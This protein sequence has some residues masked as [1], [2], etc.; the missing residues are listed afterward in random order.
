MSSPAMA[1]PHA[2]STEPH[3][4]A[5][6]SIARRVGHGNISQSP[7]LDHTEID[8]LPPEPSAFQDLQHMF[9]TPA[10]VKLGKLVFTGTLKVALAIMI[11]VVWFI[12]LAAIVTLVLL[13]GRL[14]LRRV[15]AEASDWGCDN[16]PWLM[17]RGLAHVCPPTADTFDSVAAS[18]TW[19][20]TVLE[21]LSPVDPAV[22]MR[23]GNA[24]S[25][26]VTADIQR[27]LSRAVAADPVS[28]EVALVAELTNHL[29]IRLLS[30][31]S[32][33]LKGQ[34][35]KVEE[36]DKT[37]RLMGTAVREAA[38]G[39]NP[40]LIS[41]HI[42]ATLALQELRALPASQSVRPCGKIYAIGLSSL[43]DSLQD[44]RQH[45]EGHLAT[46]RA[47]LVTL[48]SQDEPMRRVQLSLAEYEE[49]LRTALFDLL[50]NAWTSIRFRTGLG[51]ARIHGILHGIERVTDLQRVFSDARSS[52]GMIELQLD[53]VVGRLHEFSEQIAR[54]DGPCGV[55]LRTLEALMV[56]PS[57]EDVEDVG[58]PLISD[59]P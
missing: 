55:Y 46:L 32:V 20:A 38:L 21:G 16:F 33:D 34:A 35:A 59:S 57:L 5:P 36:I 53:A 28:R 54:E 8:N 22:A 40:L 17:T 18:D 13:G 45:L 23:G 49:G 25:G 42:T 1:S 9:F 52:V 51:S 43:A 29:Y 48:R 44:Q 31:G 12:V 24:A 26:P 6:A 27:A 10:I 15:V 39:M 50:G 7:A 30:S 2:T 47:A 56:R 37:V 14:A 58:T 19:S 3:G 41:I 4:T 11:L